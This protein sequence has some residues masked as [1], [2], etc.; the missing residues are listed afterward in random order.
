VT[1]VNLLPP[2]IR[3]RQRSRQT[4]LLVIGAGGIVLALIF[5]MYVIQI[6]KE[7]G[8]NEDIA[9]QQQRNAQ[10]EAQI[11]DLQ[12]FED[13]Q[14]RAQAKQALLDGAFADEVSFSGL[15]MDVSRVVSTNQYLTNLNVQLTAAAPGTDTTGGTTPSTFVGNIT[16]DGQT[17]TIETLATWLTRLGMVKGWVNP[18]VTTIDKST[19]DGVV[20]VSFTSGSDLTEDVVTERGRGGSAQDSAG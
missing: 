2:E 14:T 16:A 19:T 9:A 20:V 8:V 3:Q 13:L 1:Q 6:G 17:D 5:A 12:R 7:N 15:L 4:A 11:A 10:L 18:W